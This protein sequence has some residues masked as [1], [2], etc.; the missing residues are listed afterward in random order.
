MA[1]SAKVSAVQAERSCLSGFPGSAGRRVDLDVQVGG[2]LAQ[3]TVLG[4]GSWQNGSFR[5]AK[6]PNPIEN[7]EVD[8][9]AES[10]QIVINQSS[11]NL[12]GGDVR[13]KGQI[14]Y[15]RF[16]EM[17]FEAEGNDLEVRDI[18]GTKGKVSGHARLLQTPAVTRLT[19][20]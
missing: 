15:P 6:W 5:V 14:G 4:V 17:D 8:F 3:P 20:F 18:Y 12:L 19:G 11:M 2:T 16:Y 1:S 13:V 7:I 10:R 9:R